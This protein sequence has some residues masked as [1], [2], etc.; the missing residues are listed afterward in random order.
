MNK[1]KAKKKK[2]TARKDYF[3]MGEAVLFDPSWWDEEVEKYQES[4][5]LKKGEIVYYL[6]EIPNVSDHCI[7]CTYDGRTVP[8]IHPQDLKKAPEELL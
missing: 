3:K 6:C 4:H 2:R 1:K 5:P 7:V 8:M